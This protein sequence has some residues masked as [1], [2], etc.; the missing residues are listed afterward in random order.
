MNTCPQGHDWLGESHCI[1]STSTVNPSPRGVGI[2]CSFVGHTGP[3]FYIYQ[4]TCLPHEI[5]VQKN[6]RG[7]YTQSEHIAYCVSTKN[8]VRIAQDHRT[9]ETTPANVQQGVGPVLASGTTPYSVEAVMTTLDSR[10][11]VTVARLEIT[12]Q[13]RAIVHEAPLWV[14]VDGGKQQCSDCASVEIPTVPVGTQR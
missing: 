3:R 9:H 14:S 12:A 10:A 4:T 1:R 6:Y 11:V 13:K 2:V 5:C 7:R 8:F